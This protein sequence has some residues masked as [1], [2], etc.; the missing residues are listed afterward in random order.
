MPTLFP[1]RAVRY[2]SSRVPHLDRVVTPP[3][4]IISSAAQN[5]LYRRSPQNFIRILYGRIRSSDRPGHDRY[6]RA[7]TLFHDWLGEGILRTDRAPGFYPYRQR[8]VHQGSSYDRWGLLGVIRLGEPTIFPHEDTHTAPKEDRR[9]LL[10]AVQANLSPI[11]G[12]VEDADQRYRTALASCTR[13]PQ[14]A[15]V[16]F[17]GVQHDLWRITA[18]AS[19]HRLQLL[20][21]AKPMLLADGH[22]RYEVALGYREHLRHRNGQFTRQHPANFML[23]YAAAFDAH[24]PGILPTH[25]VVGGLDGWTLDRLAQEAN[26]WLSVTRVVDAA[27]MH[28]AVAERI[29]HGHTAVGCYAGHGQW[30][31]VAARQEDPAIRVDVELLH[32]AIVPR[33]L[34]PDPAAAGRLTVTYWQEWAEATRAVD[35]GQGTFA[36]AM[37]PPTLAQILRCI[38]GGRRLPQ[39]STYFIPKPLAGLVIH[40]LQPAGAPP[41]RPTPPTA[42]TGVI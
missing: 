29:G 28:Q 42:L 11:F 4:D 35:R 33:C 6:S 13:R 40:R 18:P 38:E 23:I 36:W 24:D 15:S 37:H 34:A 5:V 41:R 3:Y 30:A 22:H 20:L 2:A 19:I 9:Q 39:K 14:I 25:R 16:M 8:F 31:V 12:L 32:R 17:E 7:Q 1:F 27:A 26:N 21:E 10:Q